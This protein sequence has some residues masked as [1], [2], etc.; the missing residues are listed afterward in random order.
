MQIGNPQMLDKDTRDDMTGCVE[1]ITDELFEDY[2]KSNN[3]TDEKFKTTIMTTALSISD[4]ATN[5]NKILD[6][7]DAKQL[8]S[9]LQ[10]IAKNVN[11]ISTFVS[12][13]T[14]DEKLKKTEQKIGPHL[15][16]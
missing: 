11:E 4:L 15:R 5:L 8:G 7:T 12:T 1:K 14:K 2:I 16:L 6:N 13:M 3:I 9:D 10:S